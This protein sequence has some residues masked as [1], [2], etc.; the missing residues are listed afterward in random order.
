[1]IRI[2]VDRGDVR[3]TVGVEYA[4]GILAGKAED[5]MYTIVR[6]HRMLTMK[7]D[8]I[9]KAMHRLIPF[10]EVNSL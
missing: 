1:M 5:E 8:A 7:E 2:A 6:Q 9:I 3:K 10:E 4:F